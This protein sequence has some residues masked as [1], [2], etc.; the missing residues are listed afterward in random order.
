M[1]EPNSTKVCG[2]CKVE[3]PLSDFYVKR[4]GKNAGQIYPICKKCESDRHAESARNKTPIPP[5]PDI[6]EKP[7]NRCRQIKPISQFH[8][9]T[10]IKGGYSN[11]CKDCDK[12]YHKQRIAKMDDTPKVASKLCKRCG[13]VKS[14]SE[15]YKSR[16]DTTGLTRLCKPCWNARTTE[17]YYRDPITKRQKAREY[18]IKR[19]F[20]IT[21]DEYNQLLASQGGAC[22]ICG[23]KDPSNGKWKRREFKHFCVDHCHFTGV[24][25]GLLC[26]RCNV[27]LARLGDTLESAMKFIEYLDPSK[28][29]GIV[30]TGSYVEPRS[31]T[32]N[33][34]TGKSQ[35]AHNE[36]THQPDDQPSAAVADDTAPVA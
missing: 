20:G 7:C 29:T 14:A 1:A 35:P 34:Q 8:K 16:A 6:F 17:Y 9:C 27:T 5:S 21:Q 25:R 32:K 2:H 30:A 12:Q 18:G 10:S 23:T 4:T 24:I 36:T 13:Q 3:K 31:K 33:G 19:T 26:S 28:W 11:R 15:F 22:K